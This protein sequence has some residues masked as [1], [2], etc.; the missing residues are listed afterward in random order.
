MSAPGLA[1]VT[2]RGDR[3]HVTSVSQRWRAGRG[4]W[5]HRDDV[6]DTSQLEVVELARDRDAKAFVLEHHYSGSYPAAKLRY[7]LVD[8]RADRLVGVCV[9]GIPMQDKVLTNVFPD[10][11]P[12]VS[13]VE[14]S[15]L[16]LLDD[17][18]VGANAESWMVARAFRLAAGKGVRGVV[19]FSDPLRRVRSDGTIVLRG[20]VGFVYQ[21]LGA[22]HLGRS[23]RRSI[24]VLPDATMLSSRALAKV[25]AGER[26]HEYVERHLVA[27]GADPR[28]AGADPR[29]WLSAALEAVGAR[30]VRHPGNFRYAWAI[31]P[32]AQ[33][34]VVRI[35]GETCVYPK[36]AD[37][38][39]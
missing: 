26:G 28:I 29:A 9:L 3:P 22:V 21:A 19:A 5:R 27:L 10:L 17:P 12:G 6:V 20:H 37:L 38:A 25:R 13:S 16:V 34:R 8:R 32:P 11:R 1:L 33:R 15:R 2:S 36:H 14:L 30:S 39:A 18:V 31:G 35:A 24:L 4:G 7:G 23:A